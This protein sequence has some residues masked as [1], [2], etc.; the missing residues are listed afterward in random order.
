MQPSK[1]AHG[2]WSN[3][4]GDLSEML[5]EAS[6]DI[7]TAGALRADGVQIVEAGE[8]F[9]AA[10]EV[11]PLLSQYPP[12]AGDAVLVMRLAD[13]SEVVLGRIATAREYR[14]NPRYYDSNSATNANALSVSSQTTFGLAL[15]LQFDALPA[16]TYRFIGQG[17]GI[18]SHSAASGLAE[19]QFQYIANATTNSIVRSV[20]VHNTAATES[21]LSYGE[22]TGGIS[23][24]EGG[25]LKVEFQY[26]CGSSG[27]LSARNAFVNGTIERYTD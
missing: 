14:S 13:G 10:S 4:Y 19:F 24:V 9:D 15:A 17:G 26:R 27:T 16:G 5:E 2:F 20:K 21:T 11:L 3:L 7:A 6:P 8:V 12:Q 1:T 22:N 25:S 18:F 23:V